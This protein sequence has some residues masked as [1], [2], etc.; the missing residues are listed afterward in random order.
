MCLQYKSFENTVGKGEIAR[1]EQFLLFPVFNT[2]LQ[3]FLPFFIQFKIVVCNLFQFGGVKNLLF[4]KSLNLCWRP[5]VLTHYKTTNFR[6]SKL[7]E[8]ADNNFKFNE[9]GIKVSK[10]VGNVVG[11]G[12]IARYEQ[13]LLFPQCFQKACFPGA[14]KGVI[15]REWVKI[16]PTLRDQF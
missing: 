7:K 13:F 10:R 6:S 11:K 1:N 2:H 3:N 16:L 8:F 4:G 5:P 9:N 14:S 12:E 15:V